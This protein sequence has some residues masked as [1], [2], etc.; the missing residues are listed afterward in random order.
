[1]AAVSYTHLDVYKR[2][3]LGSS[4]LK[5]IVWRC[6][7][8]TLLARHFAPRI[9]TPAATWPSFGSVS[10][11]HLDVYKRQ[12]QKRLWNSL[13]SAVPFQPPAGV[14]AWR[15]TYLKNLDV[16]EAAVRRTLSQEASWVQ[17]WVEP[18][19]YT[20]L[21]VYKRQVP[22]SAPGWLMKRVGER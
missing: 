4:M 18:V 15:E 13:C 20:H 19:S 17:R 8:F 21:D 1:M 14:E 9:P 16:W 3:F 22:M 6:P 7:K 5:L 2:Q 11:T 10:Y 12:A